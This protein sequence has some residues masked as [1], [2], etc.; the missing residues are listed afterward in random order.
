MLS[1]RVGVGGLP[2]ERVARASST[3]SGSI[4]LCCANATQQR[5]VAGHMIEHAEEKIGLARRRADRFGPDPAERQEAPEPLR[6]AGDECQRRDRKLC[7]GRLR[8]LAVAAR[9]CPPLRQFVIAN[10]CDVK[11]DRMGETSA[12]PST[13]GQNVG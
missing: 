1:R 7:G 13:P 9:R 12:S 6:L 8:V 10:L 11:P 3:S 5:L 4:P 2:G